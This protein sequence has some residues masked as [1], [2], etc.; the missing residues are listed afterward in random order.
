M[1]PSSQRRGAATITLGSNDPTAAEVGALSHGLPPAAAHYAVLTTRG[2]NTA[3]I[4][5]LL[6]NTLVVSE[7]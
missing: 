6:S 1:K 2:A 7:A 3:V 4:V 5:A